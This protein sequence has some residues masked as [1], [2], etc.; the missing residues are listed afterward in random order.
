MSYRGIKWAFGAS[1]LE[2]KIRILFGL[3]LLLLIMGSFWGVNR[4]TEELIYSNTRDK[5]ND[6]K[7][8]YI[9]RVHID[10]QDFQVE[11]QNAKILFESLGQQVRTTDYTAQPL[12]LDDSVGRMHLEKAELAQD[13][14]EVQLLQG[15][16]KQAKAQQNE[17]NK[18]E[19]RNRYPDAEEVPVESPLLPTVFAERHSEKNYVYYTPLIFESKGACIGCHFPAAKEGSAQAAMADLQS[20]ISDDATDTDE[21]KRLELEKLQMVPPMFLRI[22]LNNM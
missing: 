2:R 21:F 17:Q 10:E 22:T 1:S 13:P 20:R 4:I 5:A 12:V 8:D 19:V 16:L 14:L 7:P 3:C 15:L 18:L 11:N 9:L 6:L